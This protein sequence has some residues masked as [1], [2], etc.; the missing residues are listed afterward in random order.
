MYLQ[1]LIRRHIGPLHYKQRQQPTKQQLLQER[2]TDVAQR[3]KSLLACAHDVSSVKHFLHHPNLTRRSAVSFAYNL[4]GRQE[5]SDSPG[6]PSLPCPLFSLKLDFSAVV[7]VSYLDPPEAAK[8]N[9]AHNSA[10][11]AKMEEVCCI[12]VGGA[13]LRVTQVLLSV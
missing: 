7:K 8:V 6:P 11:L 10:L 13:C 4:F 12:G 2:L 3:E 1:L 5:F 9:K